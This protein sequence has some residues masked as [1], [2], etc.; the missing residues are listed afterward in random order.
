[1]SVRPFVFTPS[2][3]NGLTFEIEFVC[4]WVMSIVVCSVSM[5]LFSAGSSLTYHVVPS[6]LNVR[7]IS[8]PFILSRVVFPKALFCSRSL[9]YQLLL[10]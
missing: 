3:L 1:V 9:A 6:V 2:I 7:T 10:T 4:V 8:R 5:A